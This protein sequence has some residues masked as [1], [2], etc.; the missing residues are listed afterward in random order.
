MSET[1]RKYCFSWEGHAADEYRDQ[2]AVGH[3]EVQY[4]FPQIET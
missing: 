4:F 2:E 3:G 1:G